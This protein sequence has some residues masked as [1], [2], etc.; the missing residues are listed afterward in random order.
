LVDKLKQSSEVTAVGMADSSPGQGI[1]KLLMKV[2][3][4][5]GKMVDRGIDLFTVN[6]D[7]IKSMGMT[8]AEGRD[9]SREV[10]SD[11]TY[12]VLVNEAMSKRM[13]WKNPIGKKFQFLGGPAGQNLERRV[14]GV[15]K[16]YHQNSLY[17][18][19][20]PLMILLGEEL[21]LVFVRTQEGDVRNSLS[22]IESIWKGVYPNDPFEYN[23]LDQDF[24]SQYKSDEKRSQ[25]FTTFS[26]LTIV[27][28]CLGLLGL[29]AFTTEQRTKEI[30]VRKVI[31]ASVQG[32]VLLVSKEFFLLV[33]LGLLIACPLAWYFTDSWLQNFA[34]RIE[35]QT[36][37]P[38]FIVSAVL[39]IV[40]TF[41]TVGF[42]VIRTATANPVKSLR[43]E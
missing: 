8:I 24:N 5:D 36:Q 28:A 1:G 13:G 7:F 30:G 22:T 9:F 39:A 10:P 32:L 4:S 40:I 2:E 19:I 33:T 26:L 15:V 17:D 27:I 35:L 12:A 11:T 16:D 42:H 41:A 18:P 3:D 6:Y 31:G 20:E 43:D 38:A 29:A 25:I 21:N 34:Y 37:W 14:I 23:F